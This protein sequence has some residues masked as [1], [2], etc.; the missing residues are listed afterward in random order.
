ML[1]TKQ[2]IIDLDRKRNA[3]REAIR[4]LEKQ[5]KEHYKGRML[6]KLPHEDMPHV[7]CHSDFK[8]NVLNKIIL[9]HLGDQ[10]KSWIAIG[11]SFFR[12]PAIGAKEM[13]EKDQVFYS[14]YKFYSWLV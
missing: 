1:S 8:I 2:E 14:L 11:N 13:L 12:L 9:C 3:N 7:A 5:T 10:S 4:A 6:G